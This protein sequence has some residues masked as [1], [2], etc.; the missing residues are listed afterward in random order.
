MYYTY[1]I[2][3]N[4]Y[5]KF[6]GPVLII[7][8]NHLICWKPCVF[9]EEHEGHVDQYLVYGDNYKT[10]REA[11]AKAVIEGKAQSID[12]AIKVFTFFF[13]WHLFMFSKSW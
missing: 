1:S 7:I 2:F 8:L 4:V 13:F 6:T 12:E 3:L 10:V 11:V 5:V 9:Q